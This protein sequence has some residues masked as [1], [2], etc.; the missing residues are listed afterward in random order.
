MCD[1][2]YI[3][4]FI[5][6]RHRGILSRRRRCRRLK[7]DSTVCYQA[8]TIESK[9]REQ[10]KNSYFIFLFL[11]IYHNSELEKDYFIYSI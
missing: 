6:M 7:W 4:L 1:Y 5:Y 2:I 3:Y 10:K 8:E 9:K 11:G